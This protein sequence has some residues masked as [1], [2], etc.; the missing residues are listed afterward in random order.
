MLARRDAQ[1][2]IKSS[3]TLVAPAEKLLRARLL[4]AHGH[5]LGLV[6]IA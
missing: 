2:W 5:S 4:K 1:R 3:P 6:D